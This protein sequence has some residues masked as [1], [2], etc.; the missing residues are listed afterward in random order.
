[1]ATMHIHEWMVN[2]TRQTEWIDR[3]GRFLW[4]AFFAGTLGGG[5]YLVSLYFNNLWGMFAAWLIVA[6]V[7]GGAHFMDLG[8]PWRAWRIIFRPGSSWMSR[9]II[10]VIIFVTAG[11]L[12]MVF[13][14]WL[15]GSAAGL[16]FK[17]LA[18]MAAFGV[19]IYSG[20]VLNTVKGV[21]FWNSALLPV[22]VGLYGVLCGTGLMIVIGL[23]G[24][25]IDLSIA[26]AASRWLLVVNAFMIGVYLLSAAKRDATGRKSVLQHLRGELAMVFWIGIAGLGIVIPL[27][28][29]FSSYFAGGTS[30]IILITGVACE[31]AGG[32]SLGYCILK[33]GAYKPLVARPHD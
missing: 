1:M 10:F 16:V 2:Y 24:G 12:Q 3:R 21:P 8:K 22:L 28:I 23:S 6:I 15:P 4:L 33:A 30:S 19:A 13:S 7:K 17:V 27:A 14:R 18:G 11:A 20:F 31:V 9:G 5:L 29:A 26:E 32:L 25:D